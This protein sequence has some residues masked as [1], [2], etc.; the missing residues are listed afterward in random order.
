M[1]I[2]PQY[3]N[4]VSH[5]HVKTRRRF[6]PNLRSAAFFST[7]LNRRVSFVVSAKACRTVEKYNGLDSFLCHYKHREGMSR[8]AIRLRKLL[9]K[10]QK[11]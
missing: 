2:K 9:L 8:K 4:N 10:R 7:L 11:A 1:G 6:L 3:G 5:S